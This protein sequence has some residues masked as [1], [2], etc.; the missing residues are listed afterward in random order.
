[1]YRLLCALLLFVCASAFGESISL[2]GDWKL[3][4]WKQPEQKITD[5]AAAKPEATIDAKVPG[6]VEIDMLNAGLIKDPMHGDNVYLLR[7]YEGYQ[8]LYQRTFE[9]PKLSDGQRA[10][11]NMEGVDTLADVFINGKKVAALQN[12]LIGHKVDITDF[13][14]DG[15]NKIEVL[16]YSAVIEGL[17][18]D[19]PMMSTPGPHRDGVEIRKAPHMYGWDIM[20]RLVSAGLWKSVSID[21]QPQSHIFDVWYVVPAVDAKKRTARIV[22]QIEARAPFDKLDKLSFNA[23]ISYKGKEVYR[24]NGGKMHTNAVRIGATIKDAN[25][26]WPR[27]MGQPSLYDAHIELLDEN[28]KKVDERKFKMGLRRV[29]LDYADISADNPG[30]FQFKIN[31]QPM[32][33]FGTNWVQ[34][35]GLHSRD[36][37][38]LPKV[39]DM[40]KDL[41]CNIVRCWGGNVYENDL[42]YDFC[43]ENGIVIWQDFSMACTPPSQSPEFKKMLD[44]EARSV[45]KR[46]RN[47]P[48]IILWSG[49][50]ENDVSYRWG[51]REFKV[52]PNLD[53]TTR[54]VIPR[55]LFD[56]DISRPYL[57]SSPYVSSEAHKSNGAITPVE[58]HLWGPRGYYKDAFYTK[59]KAKFVSEIGYHGCPNRETLERMFDPEY[60]YPWTDKDKLVWN[61]QWQCKACMPFTDDAYLAKRNN[62]MTNQARIVFGEVPRD[63]DDFIF[64]SQVVQAE[65]KKYFIEMMRSRK[66]EHGGIIWWNVRD[67]W[68]ILSDAIVDYYFSKKLAY[69]YIKRV[70][71]NCAVMVTDD[72]GVYC[73]NE[74]LEGSKVSVK[75]TDADSG[76]VLMDKG[77]I[78]IGPNSLLKIGSLDKPQGQGMLLIDYTVDG[79]TLKNHYMYGKPP[80]KL[81]DY[82]RWYRALNIKRD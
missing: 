77:D 64:A 19:L 56:L 17:K 59:S 51:F 67:G 30:K 14:K 40:V 15:E 3:S 43:D 6:N 76:R 33:A 44:E 54:V 18:R 34:V 11:L 62:L 81:S 79:T 29:E 5:P 73:A 20:P 46:L 55:V 75:I 26:W 68:P 80:F 2:D 38:L 82:K 23:T 69:Y 57:P 61:K 50:N 25:L 60:V 16:I 48:S 21:I 41:N 8:W 78:Y 7:K 66:G 58:A 63:L 24:L 1:M 49:N 72:M 70:Q 37:K 32:F 65:A 27:T 28:G 39:L 53:E 42:F 12:M 74:K 52:D 35:D 36:A 47:H 10:I 45:V 9:A 4:F 31:G 71:Q 22:L 13:L